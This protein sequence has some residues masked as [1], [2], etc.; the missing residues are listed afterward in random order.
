[1][2]GILIDIW[3]KSNFFGS[4]GSQKCQ[5][6]NFCSGGT[7]KAPPPHG[8]VKLKMCFFLMQKKYQITITENIA[9]LLLILINNKN[10]ISFHVQLKVLFQ[11]VSQS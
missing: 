11:K 1:M 10:S 5:K 7:L 9:N 8:R 3:E 6:R 2:G 4:L